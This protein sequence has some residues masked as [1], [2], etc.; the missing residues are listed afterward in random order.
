MPPGICYVDTWP[1]AHSACAG[2]RNAGL[3]AFDMEGV[4]LG[5]KDGRLTLLQVARD[6]HTVFCFDVLKLGGAELFSLLG[7][8]LGSP[9]VIKLCFD[10]RMDGDVLWRQFRVRLRRVYDIQVLYTLL[11]QA[12]TDR[13]LK[14]LA[15]VLQVPG[16]LPGAHM[17]DQV[18]GTKLR[19]KKLMAA[20]EDLFLQRPIAGD[21]LEY[22]GADVSC[23]LRMH[24]LWAHRWPQEDVIETSMGRLI[25]F[26][27]RPCEVPPP[28]SMS[29]IDFSPISADT[30]GASTCAR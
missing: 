23:L 8:L 25:L 29:V 24:R 13:F 11:F 5:K 7:P 10:C 12:R 16:V 3:V 28:R 18:L 19:M 21:L 4:N 27:N 26:I 6:D 30:L 1:M 2:L 17:L 15:H 9:N 20:Q 14:G 22:C